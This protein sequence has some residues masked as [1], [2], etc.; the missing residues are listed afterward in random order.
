MLRQPR[1]G[2]GLH[3]RRLLF[4]ILSWP[5]RISRPAHPPVA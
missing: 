3:P 5:R 4:D 2:A 1:F